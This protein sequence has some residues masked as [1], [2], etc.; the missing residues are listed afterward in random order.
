[1][2]NPLSFSILRCCA[3]YLEMLNFGNPIPF[4]KNSQ[5]ILTRVP[6]KTLIFEQIPRRRNLGDPKTKFYVTLDNSPNLPEDDEFNKADSIIGV[7]HQVSTTKPPSSDGFKWV[8]NSTPKKDSSNPSSPKQA[9][10]L[11]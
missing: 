3:P 2:I 10:G 6:S 9:S 5:E 1:M 4:M 11:Q 7:L 8:T